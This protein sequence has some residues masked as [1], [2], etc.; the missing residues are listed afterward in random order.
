M[1]T[2]KMNGKGR[3]EERQKLRW[4]VKEQMKEDRS[5]DE[6]ERNMKN[7]NSKDEWERNRWRKTEVKMN[8]KRTDEDR[9]K[10]RWMG[11]EHEEQ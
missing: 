8:C 11:K 6:W 9:Q 3:D 2:V 5:E 4:I 7:A 1:I 10:W